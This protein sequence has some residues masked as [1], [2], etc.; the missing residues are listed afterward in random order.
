MA[1]KN[2]GARKSAMNVCDVYHK[3]KSLLLCVHD[4]IT[5]NRFVWLVVDDSY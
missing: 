3:A 4:E 5:S 2:D 1:E